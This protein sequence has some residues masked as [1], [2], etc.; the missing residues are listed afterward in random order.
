ERE[1]PLRS[2]L[3][4]QVGPLEVLH[5][6]VGSSIRE[7]PHVM[8]THDV[9]TP[10]PSHGLRLPEEAHGRVVASLQISA[11]DLDRP[12]IAELEVPGRQDDPHAA[13]PEHALDTISPTDRRTH[14]RRIAPL[15]AHDN[16]VL[17]L[18]KDGGA[19]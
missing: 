1:H 14:Q 17:D 6:E 19:T 7:L 15:F 18:G 2:Q 12:E 9:V 8:N 10:Q 4:T 3:R 13:P 16:L 11:Q 5:D